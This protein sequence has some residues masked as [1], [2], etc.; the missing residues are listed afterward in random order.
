MHGTNI[1][2]SSTFSIFFQEI[3]TKDHNK[4][5]NVGSTNQ[6]KTKQ[7]LPKYSK[8][9]IINMDVMK[10]GYEVVKIDKN[11][12]CWDITK[13]LIENNPILRSETKN[14]KRRK[15]YIK[16]KNKL[17]PVYRILENLELLKIIES[18]NTP[19]SKGNYDTKEYNFTHEGVLV[20]LLLG[21]HDNNNEFIY[22]EIYDFLQSLYKKRLS[23]EMEFY[24][25]YLRNCKD[26]GYLKSYIDNMLSVLKN[27]ANMLHNTIQFLRLVNESILLDKEI[28]WELFE[29]SLEELSEKNYDLFLYSRKLHLEDV[30]SK[31]VKDYNEYQKKRFETRK[32]PNFLTIEGYCDFCKIH[33][34]ENIDI[35]FFMEM[36]T[37]YEKFTILCRRCRKGNMTIEFSQIK[38]FFPE[39]FQEYQNTREQNEILFNRDILRYGLLKSKFRVYDLTNWLLDNNKE[40]LMSVDKTKQRSENIENRQEKVKNYLK[41]LSEYNLIKYELVEALKGTAITKEYELTVFGQFTLMLLEFYRG[42]NTRNEIVEQIYAFMQKVFRDAPS[43]N[44]NTFVSEYIKKCRENHLF[45]DCIRS[46][47]ENINLFSEIENFH[48]LCN[49][50]IFLPFNNKRLTRKL[51]LQWLD[52]LNIFDNDEKLFRFLHTRK[53][54][55]QKLIEQRIDNS[56]RYEMQR[57]HVREHTDFITIK[58]ICNNCK[59][60]DYISISIIRYLNGIILNPN[61]LPTKKCKICGT[62]II[63]FFKPY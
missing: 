11:F 6:N 25:L 9:T 59:K 23:S 29:Y 41:K 28:H 1:K 52:A 51:Y 30:I 58:C 34:P 15:Q 56:S 5:N 55:L 20:A 48:D 16:I 63:Q 2:K 60:L 45:Y 10:Y 18:R 44:F 4:K 53:L 7:H 37:K 39:L 19:A 17:K 13:W 12:R 14:E 49:Q 50:L 40:Y 27:N 38:F 47:I 22:D 3:E 61:E 8:I 43:S 42:G 35:L 33:I 62:G 26:H 36:V 32:T 57:Y 46:F 54:H 21:L 24:S 31:Y